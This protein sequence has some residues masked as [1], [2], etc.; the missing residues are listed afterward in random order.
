MIKQFFKKLSNHQGLNNPILVPKPQLPS[1]PSPWKKSLIL[2]EDEGSPC[3]SRD[4]FHNV[5][6]AIL[7]VFLSFFFCITNIVC[8]NEARIH[9]GGMWCENKHLNMYACSLVSKCWCVMSM[10]LYVLSCMGKICRLTRWQPWSYGCKSPE[11]K[12]DLKKILLLM[13]PMAL[14]FHINCI[15]P[16]SVV[17]KLL[18]PFPGLNKVI[19]PPKGGGSLCCFLGMTVLN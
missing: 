12:L 13:S 18:D 9:H 16:N 14:T 15:A 10:S 6:A 19:I 5:A 8:F 3:F 17:L 2:M 11:I 1:W 4:L 7:Y